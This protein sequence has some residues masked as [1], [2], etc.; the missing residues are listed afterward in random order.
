MTAKRFNKLPAIL[1]CLIAVSVEAQSPAPR[2]RAGVVSDL[3]G[4]ASAK[5]ADGSVRE[6]APGSVIY[7]GDTI[8]T[9]AGALLRLTM[10][11][12][13]RFTVKEKTRLQIT[14]FRYDAAVPSEDRSRLSLLGGAF[15][16]LTGLIGE[17]NPD[18]VSYET[19]IAT[20][21]IR[22][23]EGELHY[24]DEDDKSSV[25]LSMSRPPPAP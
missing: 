20:I 12:R 18:K 21:G 17:R 1:L 9:G 25:G 13:S 14:D 23:T 2:F 8:L 22:G 7:N 11:D 5:A 24:D 10:T 3:R 6:L 4:A 15:R 19:P 16:F